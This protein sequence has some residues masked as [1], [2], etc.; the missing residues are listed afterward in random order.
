MKIV[1]EHFLSITTL[2]SFHGIFFNIGGHIK[3]FFHIWINTQLYLY[4]N[5]IP[6]F[7][8]GYILKV[9]KLLFCKKDKEFNYNIPH[10]FSK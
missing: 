2:S 1:L 3:G 7:L 5:C 9:F 10:T 6:S 8:S 4:L